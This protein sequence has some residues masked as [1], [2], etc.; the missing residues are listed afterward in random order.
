MNTCHLR[1]SLVT[2]FGC[3]LFMPIPILL[4]PVLSSNAQAKTPSSPVMESINSLDSLAQLS[5]ASAITFTPSFTVYLPFIA[6]TNVDR[7]AFTSLEGPQP[8]IGRPEISTINSDGSERTLLTNTPGYQSLNPAWSPDKTHIAYMSNR[9]GRYGIYILNLFDESTTQV[10]LPEG[11]NTYFD[12]RILYDVD[13]SPDGTRLAFTGMPPAGLY[14]V[15][16]VFIDGSGLTRLN[17]SSEICSGPKW[18]PDGKHIAYRGPGN[19]IRL[20][21]VNTGAFTLLPHEGAFSFD[22]LHIAWSPN[23]TRIAMEGWGTDFID[24]FVINVD[25]TGLQ[26]LTSGAGPEISPT[27]SPDGTQIAFTAYAPSLSVLLMNADGANI[28]LLVPWAFAPDWS[29]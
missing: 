20:H 4:L 6:S 28:R 9:S 10:P 12:A 14:G 17:T 27:W 21:D 29:P 24:L 22:P 1:Q 7:I 16:T 26:R 25:G 11:F 18:S 2:V 19:V 5:Y 3:I 15:Y 23:G 13:W 8:E